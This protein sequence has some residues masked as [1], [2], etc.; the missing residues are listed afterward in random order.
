MDAG[1]VLTGEIAVQLSCSVTASREGGNMSC[2][3]DVSHLSD[4]HPAVDEAVLSAFLE[5]FSLNH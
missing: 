5:Y 1:S 2:T 4:S 3:L